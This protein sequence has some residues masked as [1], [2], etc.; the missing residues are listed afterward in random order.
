MGFI[1]TEKFHVKQKNKRPLGSLAF[2]VETYQ[3]VKALVEKPSLIPFVLSDIK[4]R[5]IVVVSSSSFDDVFC[6][7]P[8]ETG[9]LLGVPFL[10]LS[11]FNSKHS[12]LSY[13][14]QILKRSQHLASSC[15]DKVDV[16]VV[17]EKALSLPLFDAAPPNSISLSFCEDGFE[18]L[19]DF[20][21]KN[22]YF[23]TDHLEAE[24]FFV[25]RGFIVDV[26]GFGQKNIYRYNFYPGDFFYLVDPL[27]GKILSQEKSFVLFSSCSSPTVSLFSKLSKKDLFVYVKDGFL[28]IKTQKSTFPEV[29]F[30]GPFLNFDYF[31]FKKNSSNYNSR[32]SSF[33]LSSACL[34]N[35]RLFYPRW[36]T[37]K[38]ELSGELFEFEDVLKIKVGSFYVHEAFGVC[39]FLGFEELSFPGEERLCLKF[40]DGILKLD[41]KKIH[42]LSFYASK[43]KQNIILNSL[44]KKGS[45]NRKKNVAF[46][47]AQNYILSTYKSFSKRASANRNPYFYDKPLFEMFLSFFK[48]KDTYDQSRAWKNTL[49]DL[50][51]TKPMDRLLCGDVGFGKTE[52]ALR[53]S[54]LALCSKRPVVVLAPTTLLSQQLF[55]CFKERF[56]PFGCVVREV[57]RLTLKNAE[58]LLSFNKKKIDILIGTHAIIKSKHPLS[59]VGMYIVDEEHRFGV[60]DKEKLLVENPLVDFLYMSAT[61]IPRSMQLSLSGIRKISTILSPPVLRKSII[62]NISSFNKTLFLKIVLEEVSRKGQTYVVDNSVKNVRALFSFLS[63]NLKGVVVAF[64]YGSLNKKD[65]NKTMRLFRSKKIDVLVSTSIIESGIDVSSANTI[66][67]NNSHL[68]GLAQLY[69]MRGRVGRSE[70]QA[71]AYLFVPKGLRLPKNSTRRLNSLAKH[72]SLGSGYQIS[73][74]DLELRG[75]GDLFGIK[76]TGLSGVGF[77][78]YSKLIA[79]A[80]R[81]S[82][83][84]TTLLP[85]VSLGGAF[86]NK[87]YLSDEGERLEAYSRLYFCSSLE[88]LASFSSSL[89]NKFG[90][91]P[92]EA[93]NLIQAKSFSLQLKNKNISS[94]YIKNLFLFFSLSFN[95]SLEFNAFI[96]NLGG[97]LTHQGFKFTYIKK[98]ENFAVSIDLNSQSPYAVV[99]K[100]IE[101]LHE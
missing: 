25:V 81:E 88:R 16:C 31:N 36:F 23:S 73:I 49:D 59:G 53:A 6:A 82:D 29:S 4:A 37:E 95:N 9:G 27:S 56:D 1:L 79:L 77:H 98:G 78:F 85:S 97:F 74:N 21:E 11:P 94:I 75:A 62:T 26:W 34:F 5:K 60:K 45:W 15:W 10:N 32:P 2:F 52:I 19:L 57:S 39:C 96:N 38:K 55:A 8:N 67:I 30:S 41:A 101:F 71:F 83:K 99:K 40:E 69:Q 7:F 33:L 20:L 100:I 35:K 68:F 92:K 51:S 47:A 43:E 22:N 65:I 13:H 72:S 87:D 86:F 58:T 84:K 93:L 91:L 80:A 90:P 17:D 48:Y 70:K 66:I 76:Q 18:P 42:L 12:F 3:N 63:N 44:N 64:I 46:R 14:Q 54:F 89:V 24:G 28:S 61:P 50:L